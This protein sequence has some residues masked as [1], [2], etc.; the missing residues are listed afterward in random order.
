MNVNSPFPNVVRAKSILP[1]STATI[2]NPSK[3]FNLSSKVFSVT[4]G[5]TEMNSWDT[6]S[7]IAKM[8]LRNFPMVF[9]KIHCYKN[10]ISFCCNTGLVQSFILTW[11][12]E[13]KIFK[14]YFLCA[15]YSLVLFL[16]LLIFART[17]N[18]VKEFI[19]TRTNSINK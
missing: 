13:D 14:R 18:D 4:V 8:A 7:W 1:P 12:R 15:P 19:I 11:T 16:M 2:R 6:A 5:S 9:K 10:A 3:S 17:A